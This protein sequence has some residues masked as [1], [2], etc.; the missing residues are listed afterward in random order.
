MSGVFVPDTGNTS[1]NL[2]LEE[3]ANNVVT[4]ID[5]GNA[6][7]IENNAIVSPNG[8]I[9]G[10]LNRWMYVTF[11]DSQY[12]ANATQLPTNKTFYGILNTSNISAQPTSF[13]NFAFTQI[14]G[15][16]ST[17][18]NLYYKTTGGRSI[19]WDANTAPQSSEWRIV[20][21]TQNQYVPIDLDDVS[22]VVVE[23]GNGISVYDASVFYASNT[24]PIAPSGGSYQFD[25]NE[26]VPP[27]G[28][29]TSVPN[30][31]GTDNNV[32]R[33]S[34]TFSS[35]IYNIPIVGQT[36]SDP[37]IVYRLGVDGT[38]GQDATSTYNFPVYT[39][40]TTQPG[41]PVTGTGSYNFA[42]GLGVAPTGNPSTEIWYTN[43]PPGTDQ[44]W[45]SYAGA[46]AIGQG[47]DDYLEWSV[48]VE[49][50]QTGAAG[51]DGLS[52]YN[53][54]VFRDSPTAPATPTGGSYNFGTRQA[55]PP[56]GW[57]AT[58]PQTSNVWISTARAQVQG[59]TGTWTGDANS[60][61]TPTRFTGQSGVNGNTTVIP[62]IYTAR[63]SAP[64]QPTT[65]G[66][67]N[68]ST[69]TLIP[70]TASGIIWYANIQPGW[71]GLSVWT[72]Q[73]SFTSN[74]PTANIANTT[75][76]TTPQLSF[77][78]GPKGDTGNRGFV[79]LAFVV[80]AT[81]PSFFSSADFTAAFQ[82]S[83]TNVNPPIGLGYPPIAGDAAQFYWK[84]P[85]FGGTDVTVVRQFDG[86]QWLAVYDKVISGNVVA[87]GSIT[88]AQMKTNDLYTLNIQST[89]ATPNNF[90]S[91]GF[92]LSSE[93]GA[94]RFGGTVSIGNNLT[95]GS[96]AQ[97]GSGAS[98]GSSLQ[99]GD[100]ARI[101]Q[102]LIVGTSAQI[103]A[104]ATIGTN[105]TVGDTARIGNNLVVGQFMTVGSS[106]QI[107]DS[108]RVGNNMIVGNSLVIGASANIGQNLNIGQN[109]RIGGNLNIVG[110]VNNGALSADALPLGESGSVTQQSYGNPSNWTKT[111]VRID[112][113]VATGG[114]V[115]NYGRM[116]FLSYVPKAVYFTGAPFPPRL[117]TIS[118][119]LQ[120]NDPSVG[121]GPALYVYLNG[122]TYSGGPPA[123]DDLLWGAGPTPDYPNGSWY[124]QGR[125]ARLTG[126]SMRNNQTQVIQ[127]TDNSPLTRFYNGTNYYAVVIGYTPT[128][129]S[130]TVTVR[131]VTMTVQEI[132]G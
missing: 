46:Y 73:A 25:T 45:A 37:V 28:W 24:A 89:N 119:D 59:T 10:Y 132:T 117:V 77:S 50:A 66:Y 55:V 44:L 96:S 116:V 114:A 31:V 3:L 80:T 110:L 47:I 84:N 43:P 102:G 41:T 22:A 94:A 95:V 29:V 16:F 49:L 11:A 65:S 8:Q 9:I 108:L 83:R 112:P 76:W 32:Y 5:S 91:A 82:A 18:R 35:N 111:N 33:S 107:G 70:P 23:G 99:V 100:N 58:P 51:T 109:C 40:K 74:S 52:V 104:A 19:Q 27:T 88:A 105:L 64:P 14:A 62:V 130:A 127:F 21:N 12:G 7:Q 72:S 1:L 61:S 86:S 106:A 121:L 124:L 2:V 4:S 92:W 113:I 118:F 98:I 71:N 53:Y 103:G 79:P 38:P 20:P 6:V 128:A 78:P 67:Y 30:I 68:F 123:N 101:G 126:Q 75:S 48:P 56:S 87:T 129:T 125:G 36:W 131:N 63:T 122:K 90:N 97:I 60:W 26:L 115:T 57:L 54:Q 15:G 42:T 69:N 39:R 93:T 17:N 81:N 34:Y 85:A 120:Y 13:I